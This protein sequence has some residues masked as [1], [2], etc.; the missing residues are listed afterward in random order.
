[1]PYNFSVNVV[2]KKTI[3]RFLETHADTDP[4]A[5]EPLSRWYNLFRKSEPKNF[6]ELRQTFASADF[7]NPFTIFNVGGN[8]YRVI[9]LIDYESQFAKIRHVFTHTEYDKWNDER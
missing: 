9:T 6:A 5:T 2:S 4:E 3:R 7:T 1:M 8:K